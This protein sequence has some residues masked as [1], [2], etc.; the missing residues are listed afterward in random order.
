M[1]E[2]ITSS[3]AKY[4]KKPIVLKAVVLFI[5]ILVTVGIVWFRAGSPKASFNVD[6]LIQ[7][8]AFSQDGKLLAAG[9]FI[10][11]TES[12]SKSI[13][14]LW[15]LT[16]YQQTAR[17]VAHNSELSTLEFDSDG[18]TL[19]SI[20]LN[21]ENREA[22]S[23]LKTWDISTQKQIG[24]TKTVKSVKH[25]PV[26]SPDGSK[27]GMS[28]KDGFAVIS[29]K[30]GQD[31]IRLESV[32]LHRN[33]ATFSTDGKLFAIGSGDCSKSGPSPFPGS[34]GDLR[35]W[36]VETGRLLI[37]YNRHW[38]GPITSVAFSPDGK[39]IA[40]ASLD[41]TIKIWNVPEH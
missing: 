7:S 40:T 4:Q 24:V 13:I 11:E 37:T 25:F 2:A 26:V 9:T 22:D 33:C 38:F 12:K 41:G 19:R 8:I 35:I 30:T 31:L 5:C 20:A 1:V 3:N 34:N 23:E 32:P 6:G 27:F 28:G 17:W 14:I 15:D 21:R 16:T 10:F 29:D 18:A 36:D 39:L